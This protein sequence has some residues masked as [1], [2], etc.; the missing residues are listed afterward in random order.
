M[1]VIVCEAIKLRIDVSLIKELSTRAQI[2][3][4]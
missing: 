1:T 4:R 2:Y 3:K